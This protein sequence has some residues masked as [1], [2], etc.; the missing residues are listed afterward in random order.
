M[1]KLLALIIFLGPQAFAGT[2]TGKIVLPSGRAVAGG[3]ITLT[4]SQLGYVAGSYVTT[5]SSVPCYT[6][7]DGSIVGEPDPLVAPIVTANYGAG[8]LAAATYYLKLTYYDGTGESLASPEVAFT[9]TGTGTMN[10]AL[11]ALIPSNATGIKVY[12]STS[13]GTETQQGSATFAGGVSFAQS[14]ALV[15]GSALPAVNSSACTLVFNDSIIPARTLYAMAVVDANG[16]SVAGFPQNY[17][18]QGSTF[19]ISSATPAGNTTAVFPQAIIASPTNHALQ[20]ISGPLDLGGYGISNSPDPG[21]QAINV[22]AKPYS[23]ACDNATD[24]TIAIQ[25]AIAAG[26]VVTLPP[27]NKTCVVTGTVTGAL[28]LSAGQVFYLNGST[29]RNNGAAGTIV[30]SATNVDNWAIL[31][32]GTLQGVNAGTLAGPTS[33]ALILA[34]GGHGWRINNTNLINSNGWAIKRDPGA[35]TA[36][37]GDH[38][39]IAF[40]TGKNDYY[41]M[42]FTAGTGAEYVDVIANQFSGYNFGIA[43]EAGNINFIGNHFV[44]GVNGMYIGPGSN[45]AHGN[46]MGNFVNHNSGYNIKFDTVTNGMKC[47][48]NNFYADSTSVGRIIFNAS[49]GVMLEDNFIDSVIEVDSPDGSPNFITNNQM[50]GAT[51]QTTP[52]SETNLVIDGNKI[53]SGTGWW[54]RNNTLRVDNGSITVSAGVTAATVTANQEITPRSNIAVANGANADVAIGTNTFIKLTGPTGVF[55]ISGFTGGA[56]GRKLVVYNSV[57]FAWTI[58]NN[59]TSTAANR[60]LTLTGAD[61]TLR[62][63][64]SSATFVYDSAQSL[65]ILIGSN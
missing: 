37:R 30:F 43:D 49:H 50:V 1:K 40:N 33:E 17:Y 32:P 55:S 8:T 52:T 7:S 6:T 22:K 62:A 54:G 53:P 56:D 51:G 20:S 31:G 38:G 39:I 14:V 19:V 61:V 16:S 58:T 65:W 5:A 11:P 13:A 28:A 64:Q 18:L 23:A 42:E 44:D 9:M 48:G 59:A 3:T 63:G 26:K 29:I 24:D 46:C 45:H 47:V 2:V 35:S 34:T 41:G 57:A 12:I 4:L 36:P 27:G 25:S 21:N 15:A 60:I 10:V